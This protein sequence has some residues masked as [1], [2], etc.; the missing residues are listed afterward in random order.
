MTRGA[1]VPRG[2]QP[3][4]TR[5]AALLTPV[6]AVIALLTFLLTAPQIASAQ[7]DAT[8]KQADQAASAATSSDGATNSGPTSAPKASLP[9][10]E[11]EVMCP[12]CGTLLSLATEAPQAQDQRALIRRLIDQGLTKEQIKDRLVAEFGPEVLATPDTKGFDLLAWV[13]PG[14]AIVLVGG[15]IIIG[16]RRWRRTTATE[17]DNGT[18]SSALPSAEA[19]RL[20]DDLAR[21]DL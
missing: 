8:N 5:R 3:A 17:Q 21:Y 18:P 7:D 6:A 2:P 15:A 11:D 14:A 20:E 13:I 16:L 12:V 10:I 19:K 9:D 4:S 1:L